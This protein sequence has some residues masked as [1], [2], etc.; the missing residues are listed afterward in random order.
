MKA[1]LLSLPLALA[2]PAAEVELA[3]N[4]AG[5]AYVVEQELPAAGPALP[6][7]VTIATAITPEFIVTGLDASKTYRFRIWSM[8]PTGDRYGVSN[9]LSVGFKRTYLRVTDDMTD[10]TQRERKEIIV[11]VNPD[12]SFFRLSFTE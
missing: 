12:R 7:W 8:M 6:E 4:R 9:V 3:W 2:S 5:I 1:A 10:W 11:A